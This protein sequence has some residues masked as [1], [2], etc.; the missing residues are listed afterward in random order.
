MNKLPAAVVLA[1]TSAS[2][3]TYDAAHER[4]S[5]YPNNR[6]FRLTPRAAS[7]ADATRAV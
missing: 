7:K 6:N 1:K 5:V 2:H 3:V 4:R